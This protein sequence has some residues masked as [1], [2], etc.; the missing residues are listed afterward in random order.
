MGILS[1]GDLVN[2]DGKKVGHAIPVIVAVESIT[3]F[4]PATELALVGGICGCPLARY[5][6]E[7]LFEKMIPLY[8]QQLG[9]SALRFCRF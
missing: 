3:S 7:L 9:R 2:V 6:W 4:Y 8:R 1:A 5:K